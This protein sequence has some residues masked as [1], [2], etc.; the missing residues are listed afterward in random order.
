[1]QPQRRLERA[2][3]AIL[4]AAPLIGCPPDPPSEEVT[5]SGGLVWV[6]VSNPSSG[7]DTL[8]A[9]I[10]L[11]PYSGPLWAVGS[12]EVPGSGDSEWRIERR[13][14]SDGALTPVF[15]SGGVVTSN[16]SSGPDEATCVLSDGTYL[17]IGGYDSSPGNRQ[18]RIEKRLVTDGSLDTA[19]GTGGVVTSNPSGGGDEVTAIRWDGTNLYVV[20]WDESPGAG[21][22]EWRIEKRSATSGTLIGGFGA[23]G[24]VT[25]NPST[26]ADVPTTALGGSLGLDVAGYDS[27]PGDRQWRIER[28]L[29]SSGALDSSFANAGVLTRNPSSGSDEV[30]AM[31]AGG[32]IVVVGT[33]ESPGP[34]D[35]QWRME[36]IRND[37]SLDSGFGVGGVITFN[38]SSGPDLLTAAV[39][40]TGNWFFV[41][42]SDAAPGVAGA[43]WEWRLEE[44]SFA[45]GAFDPYWGTG[46]VITSN[47]TAG[48]DRVYATWVN[49]N[50]GLFAG[51]Q[52]S[53][54]DTSWRI[55]ARG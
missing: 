44:R 48:S 9:V 18:W 31:A 14:T 55:E 11:S 3:I 13:S 43:D 10:T 4:A 36:G 26:G 23:G 19:F 28:R 15:G 16:P 34:G 42:G 35:S 8:R 21:D 12:D 33:D 49:S 6:A 39:P 46:G 7:G 41:A 38:P 53:P 45:T 25:S 30:T 40:L 2:V 47:P 54:P 51:T 5:P 50:P 20:G 1:M 27:A 32:L 17:F 52:G 22:T 29:L 37:G 24:V